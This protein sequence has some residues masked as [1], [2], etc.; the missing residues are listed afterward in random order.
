MGFLLGVGLLH[1]IFLRN[2]DILAPYALLG[3]VLLGFRHLS[4]KT[5][6]I[7]AVFLALVPY[8][9]DGVMHAFGLSWP[10]RPT[11]DGGGY[12]AENLAWLRHWYETNPLR[13]WPRVLAL[14]LAGILIGRFRVIERLATSL[15]GA[16]RLFVVGLGLALLTRISFEGFAARWQDQEPSFAHA[17]T[18]NLLY[19]LSSWSLAATYAAILLL[20]MQWPAGVVWSWPLRAVGRMAFTNYLLQGL[21]VVP[22]CLAFGLFDK[23][24]P[25]RGLWLGLANASVQVLF[26]VWWL[27]RHPMGP[28]ERI[29]RSVTYKSWS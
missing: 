18:L 3:L 25:S 22:V 19:Q 17:I 7:A 27:R 9:V 5:L 21:I 28:L 1:G 26:S 20:L 2:G 4:S 11:S 14:M 23:V 10:A 13:S 12:L 15:A 6:A 8:G 16:G 24:T 29:W